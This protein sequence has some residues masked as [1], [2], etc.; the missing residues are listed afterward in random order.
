M[1]SFYYWWMNTG[2][3]QRR[4]QC[5]G[6]VGSSGMSIGC[7]ERGDK[8]DGLSLYTWTIP[9]PQSPNPPVIYLVAAYSP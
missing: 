5:V 2:Q 9:L 8:R 1:S 4:F 3:L 6:N 7:P